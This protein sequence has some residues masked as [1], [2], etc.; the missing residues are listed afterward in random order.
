M[1]SKKDKQ[2]FLFALVK[3]IT[4]EIYKTNP[5]LSIEVILEIFKEWE[6]EIKK[7]EENGNHKK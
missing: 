1:I 3:Q 4:N 6:D 2:E 7:E 5:N